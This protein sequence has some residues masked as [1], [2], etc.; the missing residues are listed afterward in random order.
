MSNVAELTDS[1]VYGL[2]RPTLGDAQGSLRG[3]VD[4]PD[5]VW[6]EL[7]TASGL[8]GSEKTTD[9]VATM[10]KAMLGRGGGVAMCGSALNIRL[11]AYSAL[12]T[13]KDMI[14]R[15]A[16]VGLRPAL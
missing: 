5:A 9:A 1:S 6:A 12:A 10:I 16:T 13:V 4:N 11:N 2:R 15:T 3:A 7:L 14:A 8:T